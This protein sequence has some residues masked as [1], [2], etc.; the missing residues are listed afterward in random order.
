GEDSFWFCIMFYVVTGEA[1]RH[2][3]EVRAT[4]A[5]VLL[6]VALIV[7]AIVVDTPQREWPQIMLSMLPFCLGLV[8]STMGGRFQRRQ[9]EEHAA[10]LATLQELERSKA[11]LERA[12]QQ[13]QVYAGTVEE[14]AVANERNR[15]ARELHDILGYT[16]A[17]VVVKAE[18]AKRLLNADPA[19]AS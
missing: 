15:L 4:A 14:L 1:S 19:R 5:I 18:A 8:A 10:R 13:L 11:A 17:T 7:L 12:N 9:E 2:L 3:R 6:I 16:L